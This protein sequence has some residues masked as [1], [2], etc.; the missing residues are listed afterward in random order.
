MA[1][2]TKEG[3]VQFIDG[4]DYREIGE[5]LDSYRFINIKYWFN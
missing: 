1:T 3:F 4:N 2:S 5:I